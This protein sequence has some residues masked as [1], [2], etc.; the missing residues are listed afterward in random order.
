MLWLEKNFHLHV[1]VEHAD[2]EFD[3]LRTHVLDRHTVVL[4][5]GQRNIGTY[6]GFER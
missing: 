3:L 2:P 1:F 5:L 6:I 4:F